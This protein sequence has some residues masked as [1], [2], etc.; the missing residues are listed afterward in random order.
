MPRRTQAPNAYN[1]KTADVAVHYGI[2]EEAVRRLVRIGK[3]RAI[4]IG[5]DRRRILRFSAGD[6]RRFELSRSASTWC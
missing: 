5:S 4:N 6:L 2:S 3:L 1:L